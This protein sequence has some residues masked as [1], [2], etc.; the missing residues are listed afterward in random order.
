MGLPYSPEAL[1]Q[2]LNR[3]PIELADGVTPE[4]VM[5][6]AL[7]GID[8]AYRAHGD[9]ARVSLLAV[10]ADW[11]M[12]HLARTEAWA[13]DEQAKRH[14]AEDKLVE[15]RS[16]AAV[17]EAALAT[18]TAEAAGLRAEVEAKDKRIA[19][20]SET[21]TDEGGTV[22]SPPT[23]WAYAK[24][25]AA[26]HKH[27]ADAEALRAAL[28]DAEQ[29]LREL[30][31]D[32]PSLDWMQEQEAEGLGPLA[33]ARTA[34]ARAATAGEGRSDGAWPS[35]CIKPN[36]CSRHRTCVY[37]MSAEKCRH[38][39]QDLTAAIAQA[40]APSTSPGGKDA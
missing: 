15:A 38:F 22:W 5:R 20:L 14:A 30:V 32:V 10:Q 18:A 8:I 40:E 24:A 23:A 9:C 2:A 16:R 35:G 34:L 11:I 25:C 27:R 12:Q 4:E 29:T 17:A 3:E 21:W 1:E 13:K 6:L 39:G 33:A 26:L 36:A 37:A 28:I 7:D 19:E 31:R